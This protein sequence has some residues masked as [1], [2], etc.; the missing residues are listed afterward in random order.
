MRCSLLGMWFR[1]EEIKTTRITN[2]DG[3]RKKGNGRMR[4]TRRGLRKEKG[5]K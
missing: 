5:R 3:Q 2:G 1:I 4:A